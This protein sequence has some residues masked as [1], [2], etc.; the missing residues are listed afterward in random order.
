MLRVNIC[1]RPFSS[2]IYTST[3]SI[4][5]FEVLCTH[6]RGLRVQPMAQGPAGVMPPFP[7]LSAVLIDLSGT[8]HIEDTVVPGAVEALKRLREVI[9]CVKFVTNTTKESKRVLFERLIQLGFSIDQS[10]IFTSL[11]AARSL[12]E[13]KELRPHLMLE[14]EALE[15]FQGIPTDNPNA[16]VVGLAPS[17]FSYEPLNQA[18]RLLLHGGTLIGIHKA[19]YYK[20]K[21]GLALGPGPFVTALEYATGVTA[22]VVGK[23]ESSFF[24]SALKELDVKPENA[25]MIGD[26]VKDDV[27]GAQKA[28]LIGALVKTGKYRHGDVDRFGEKPNYVFED[29][30]QA[31]EFIMLNMSNTQPS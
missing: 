31:V 22:E 1:K 13:R 18:F 3:L 6:C 16:L 27:L 25:I 8:L 20:R 30:P 5:L 10:E 21:D 14:P 2:R 19:R 23:P 12:V 17:L 28:G 29:F 9:P 4:K 24:L 26:D 15:D 7:S 11:T